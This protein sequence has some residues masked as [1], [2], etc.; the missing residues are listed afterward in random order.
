[1]ENRPVGLANSLR[2]MGAGRQTPLWSH[3]SELRVPVR[4]IVGQRDDRY[5][6]LAARMDSLLP[7]SRLTVVEG[8]GHTVHADQPA[9]FVN[10]IECALV[11]SEA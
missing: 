2:G 8:A 4:L 10:L 7:D 1:L 3:L 5:R 9:E 6:A 11:S